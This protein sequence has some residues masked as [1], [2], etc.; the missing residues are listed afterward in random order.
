ML[1]NGKISEAEYREARSAPLVLNVQRWSNNIA[2]YFVEDVR[3]YLERKYGAEAVHEKGLRVYTTLNVQQQ[4]IAE[5]ALQEGLR[6]YDKRHGWRGP[7][8]NI[9]K[10]PPTLPSGLL[11]T[12]ETYTHPDWRTPLDPGELVHGLVIDVKPDHALVRFGEQT[13]RVVPGDYAWTGR[14]FPPASFTTGDVDL[15]LV[16]EIKGETLHVTLD[17]HPQVQGALIAIE[18]SSGAIKAMVGGYDFE[19]SKFNRARQAAR[20][21]G[22]SF[23]VYVYAQALLDGARPFDTIVDEPLSFPSA[24]GPWSPHNY[25]GKYLGTITLLHALA[26]S[27][28]IPAVRLLAR[29]GVDKVIK[30]CRKFRADFAAGGESAARPGR[31]GPD[32]ARTHF[33]LQHLPRRR[34]AHRAAARRAR[35]QLR[36]PPHRRFPAGSHRRPARRPSP[37][38]RLPCCARSS[39]SGTATLAKA[40]AESI[41]WRARPAPPTTS[42]MA[43]SKAL[44]LHSPAASGWATTIIAPWGTR[45]KARAWRCPSGC[46]SW[47]QC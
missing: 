33:R 7:E 41:R 25:D 29:V 3:L 9:L 27:R 42:A 20:Q 22:S 26:E 15:F 14:S 19:E 4:Q 24:S 16:K 30:L 13:A 5:K 23:K 37:G 21:A 44:P 12:L 45:K 10:N 34:R 32:A 28:N 43:G 6:V 40:L 1:E 18:N 46:S 36:R 39:I 38:W 31:L 35:H 11:A 47:S 8:E 2:P 17:Q